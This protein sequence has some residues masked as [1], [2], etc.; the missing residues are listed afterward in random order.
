M[1]PPAIRVEGNGI[2]AGRM[3]E[4]IHVLAACIVEVTDARR[5]A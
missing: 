5:G 2:E 3:R 4:A 1:A